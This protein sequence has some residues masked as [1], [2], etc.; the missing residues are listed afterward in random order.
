MKLEIGNNQGWVIIDDTSGR[1]MSVLVRDAVEGKSDFICTTSYTNNHDGT[2]TNMRATPCSNHA[3][4]QEW[5]EEES[6]RRM[7]VIG[8]NGN[9]GEHYE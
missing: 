9:T 3:R 2:H 6:N 1:I 7:R 5:D 8:Q 4:Q